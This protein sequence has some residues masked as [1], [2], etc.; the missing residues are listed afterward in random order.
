MSITFEDVARLEGRFVR[1]GQRIEERSGRPPLQFLRDSLGQIEGQVDPNELALLSRYLLGNHSEMVVHLALG[2]LDLVR[3]KLADEPERA[4]FALRF[5][6]Q[7][8][9]TLTG[10]SPAWW[11]PEL[12]APEREEMETLLEVARGDQSFSEQ[13]LIHNARAFADQH[14]RSGHH[15]RKL[16]AGLRLLVEVLENPGASPRHCEAARAALTYFSEVSDAIPDDLG[17]VGMLDDAAAIQHAVAEIHPERGVI[18]ALLD[19]VVRDWPFV[20][21]LS[22][23]EES[24]PYPVSEFV[25][26]SAALVL[27][28]V[29]ETGAKGSVLIQSRLGPLPFLI[30]VLRALSEVRRVLDLG[31]VPAFSRGERLVG[32]AGRG[33]VEF[34][35]Y[36][37]CP[38][39]SRIYED[40]EECDP[41]EATH[42]ELLQLG[43]KGNSIH[44]FHRI[45]DIRS[46]RRAKA[47]NALKGGRVAFNLAKKPVGT[48]EKIFGLPSPAI[49]R[50]ERNRILFVGPAGETRHL[51]SELKILGSPIVDLLPISRERL[52]DGRFIR[53][54]WTTR[55]GPGGAPI[56]TV[57]QST[58][59]AL[60]IAESDASVAAVVSPVGA[61]TRDAANLCRIASDGRRVLAITSEH[62][63]EALQQFSRAGF[64]F[65]TWSDEWLGNL[66]WPQPRGSD[67]PAVVQNFEREFRRRS[68]SQTKSIA[69]DLPGLEHAFEAAV[70]LESLARREK[71]ETLAE[72][73][74]E[75]IG[76][77]VR[78]CRFLAPSGRST[79][80]QLQELWTEL[81]AAVRQR[82]LW[83]R[84][85]WKEQFDC[86][87]ASAHE[88]I[89][90]LQWNN[91]KF[92][93][94]MAWSFDHPGGLVAVPGQDRTFLNELATPPELQWLDR[95]HSD[96]PETPILVP[97]WYG[98]QRMERL[99]YPPIARSMTLLLYK[100]E[101]GWLE[102]SN[103]RASRAAA[104]VRELTERQRPFRAVRRQALV[105]PKGA[106]SASIILPDP[107]EIALRGR[108]IRAIQQLG[109][110]ND[111]TVEARLVYFAGGGWAAFT[112]EHR[113]LLLLSTEVDGD[114]GERLVPQRAA[115]VGAGDLVLLVR[116]SD[117]DAIRD[118]VDRVAPA[119]LRDQ[120]AAWRD[121]LERALRAGLS[122]Q[123][124]Q[125]QLAREGCKRTVA[126]L[127]GWVEDET[128]IGPRDFDRDLEAILRVTC[129]RGLQTD[130]AACKR[131]IE[132]LWR[133]HQKCG[134]ELTQEVVARVR[135]RLRGGSVLD[136][137]LEIEERVVLVVIESVDPEIVTVPLSM[138]N[139]LHE[140]AWRG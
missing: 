108:R 57:V 42:F 51:A 117:R 29:L 101:L 112:P 73:C 63:G 99:L 107:D 114:S 28:S 125:R 89:E 126:T 132:T 127:R 93:A 124:L 1:R 134:H 120:A 119:G 122:Y 109:L 36:V 2:A 21:D 90:S 35:G 96:D 45:Q 11:L 128:V 41:G 61:G 56:L 59:E 40:A 84:D 82:Q 139:R 133:L 104:E 13:E 54:T 91:P 80:K 34:V 9:R 123:E 44:R 69:L 16:S 30:A 135:N 49:L 48:L 12:E 10:E 95:P 137:V 106:E 62:D 65:W 37:K 60:E 103:A 31:S 105:D 58:A 18:G 131:A 15:F 116:G 70:E 136:E 5:A 77:L 19:D 38:D 115:E 100:S 25:L 52:A 47:I 97:A 6:L 74:S 72:T 140:D 33:E 81:A 17:P 98:R 138:A 102:R 83:W 20:M 64:G 79:W 68:G 55:R 26:V 86:I 118:A 24:N 43:K 76:A 113:V 130:L 53:D 46:L 7:R 39:G 4:R 67:G 50:T 92:E 3:E 23:G 87:F 121:A 8:L 71:V 75:C 88:A 111:R 27:D 32:P 85:E 129:D 22:L 110:A 14:E 94:A 66:E 78:I